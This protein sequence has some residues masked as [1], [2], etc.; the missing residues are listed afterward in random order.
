MVR[1]KYA[2]FWDTTPEGELKK[3]DEAWN[4][5]SCLELCQETLIFYYWAFDKKENVL[6]TYHADFDRYDYDNAIQQLKTSGK[7]T[8]E[9]DGMVFEMTL[10]SQKKSVDIEFSVDLSYP[11][12]RD[13]KVAGP[14]HLE[15]LLSELYFDE[16]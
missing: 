4:G 13:A 7:A 3:S 5:C 1:Y 10:D 14:F 9:G 6:N 12:T 11:R 2:I 16:N 8:V 15:R